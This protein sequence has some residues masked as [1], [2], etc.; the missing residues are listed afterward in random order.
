MQAQPEC[1]LSIP[2]LEIVKW[3]SF[4]KTYCDI[5]EIVGVSRK[6]V[7]RRMDRAYPATGTATPQG[8]VALALRK[9][10]IQ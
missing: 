7:S 10:W 8:I 3:L 5:A 4:G 6:A 2:Q 1:P 9:G